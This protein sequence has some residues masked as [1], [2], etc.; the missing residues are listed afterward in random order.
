MPCI[1]ASPVSDLPYPEAAQCGQPPALVC[2]WCRGRLQRHQDCLQ[3]RSLHSFT[4]LT[5]EDSRVPVWTFSLG[6]PRI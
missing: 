5:Q 3:Q 4:Q 1:F 2:R 6:S